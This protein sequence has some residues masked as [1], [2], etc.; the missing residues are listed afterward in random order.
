MGSLAIVYGIAAVIG[1]IYT[2]YSYRLMGHPTSEVKRAQ[3]GLGFSFGMTVAVG[4][5]AACLFATYL[6]ATHAY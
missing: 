2:L 3:G 5:G 6:W 4:G 1:T